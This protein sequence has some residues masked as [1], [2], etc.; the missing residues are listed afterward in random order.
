MHVNA[1]YLHIRINWRLKIPRKVKSKPL[2]EYILVPENEALNASLFRAVFAGKKFL[3]IKRTTANSTART[4]TDQIE[5]NPRKI[6]LNGHTRRSMLTAFANK[7]IRRLPMPRFTA[8]KIDDV[9]VNNVW[10]K[11][12]G[13]HFVCGIGTYK[14][15]LPVLIKVFEGAIDI[16][17]AK[18]DFFET[19]R[20]C[21]CSGRQFCKED[22]Y[23]INPEL[24]KMTTKSFNTLYRQVLR[25][26]YLDSILEITRRPK[27]R[28]SR[29]Y[30][31]KKSGLSDSYTVLCAEVLLVYK[32]KVGK[33]LDHNVLQLEDVLDNNAPYGLPTGQFLR[34]KS[35]EELLEKCRRIDEL[36][37][38]SFYSEAWEEAEDK[39]LQLVLSM[40][41]THQLLLRQTTTPTKLETPGKPYIT[42]S[43]G[44]SRSMLQSGEEDKENCHGN[45]GAVVRRLPF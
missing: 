30:K 9:T 28:D 27:F 20:E 23:K 24:K 4:L 29:G 31:N 39:N 8:T 34:E 10:S 43:S 17:R 38:K 22:L 7:K 14:K 1:L 2:P 19:V 42:P 12:F 11:Y 40:E 5:H 25:I 18:H 36:Y 33:L 21:H 13:E 41:E 15:I 45:W 16:K 6:R 44:R 3:S 32:A 35:D 26:I 37:M